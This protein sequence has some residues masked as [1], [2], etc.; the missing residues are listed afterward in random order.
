MEHIICVTLIRSS[1]EIAQFPVVPRL[2]DDTQY[3]IKEGERIRAAAT[4]ESGLPYVTS[5]VTAMWDV[6]TWIG[7]KG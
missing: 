4:V 2:Y 6:H 5:Q 3:P 1:S 7:A